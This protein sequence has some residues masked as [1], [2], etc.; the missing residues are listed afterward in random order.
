MLQF[1]VALV[2]CALVSA[3]SPGSGAPVSVSD[4]VV[5]EPLSGTRMTAAY[6]TI[7][8]NSDQPISIDRVTSPQFGR[9]EMHQTIL[10]DG[11][12][13]MV[14]LAPLIVDPDSSVRFAIGGKHLMM[15]DWLQEIVPGQ[16]ITLEFHYDGGGLL[17]V[18]TTVSERVGS[19]MRLQ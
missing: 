2:T 3:C 1:V 14:A 10:E 13:R 8:N 11:V 16:Q 15:S 6:L 5:P 7:D 18:N 4:V 9:I 17:I 12:A 19:R